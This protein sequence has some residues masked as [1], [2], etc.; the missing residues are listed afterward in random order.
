MKQK[1]F[2]AGKSYVSTSGQEISDSDK[3]HLHSVVDSG[4]YTDGRKC[5]EFRDILGKINAKKHV[6][7]TNSGSSA[8]LVAMS[9]MTER[10]HRPFKYILTCATGFPTTVAPIYQTGH[11]PIY[12][13]I[14]PENLQPDRNQTFDMKL[15]YAGDIGFVVMAHTLGFPFYEAYFADSLPLV[16]DGCDALG[17]KI[18]DKPVGYKADISTLSFFP[19]HH[20]TTGQGG[21]VLTDDAELQK[22]CDSYIHWGRH[23]FP[24]DT[25]ITTLSGISKIQ[26]IKNGDLVL[27]HTGNFNAVLGTS[28]RTGFSG[29]MT[30]IKSVGN[31]EIVSTSDHPFFVS[32]GTWKLA[33]DLV[34]GDV[35]LEAIPSWK[36]S[37]NHFYWEY[38]TD[39]TDKLVGHSLSFDID[40]FRLMGY[41][42][43]QGSIAK[44]LKGVSGYSVDKYFSYRVDFCFNENKVDVIDDLC[45]LM[46]RFFDLSPC[47]TIGK[48]SKAKTISFKSRSAYEFF[49]LFCGVG[50]FNKHI[51][52]DVVGYDFKKLIHLVHGFVL[53]DGNKNYQGYTFSSISYELMEQLR[54]ILLLNGIFVSRSCRTFDKHKQSIVNGRKIVQ[55]H[56]LWTYQLY[57]KNAERFSDLCGD[58][59]KSRSSKSL[60]RIVGGY[61]EHRILQ[62]WNEEVSNIPVYN[63]EVE[64]DN[65]YHAWGVAVHNCFCEPGQNNTCGKR[66]DNTDG[67]DLPLGWDHKYRFE[68]LGYNL[69]MTEFQAALGVSQAMILDEF[70]KKRQE[71]Y[72]KLLNGL[73]VFNEYISFVSVPEWSKPSPFGFPILVRDTAPFSAM[74]L[75]EYLEL[76]KVG[77]RRVFGG[78]LTRQPA[79]KN[80]YHIR[81]GDLSGSDKVMNDMLWIGCHPALTNEMLDYVI[82]TFDAFFKSKGL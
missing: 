42:I 59:Y 55:R 51:P 63:F 58:D 3:L 29:D 80:L 20:I 65:S 32:P 30:H 18:N 6:M 46:K 53:G 25:P 49:S 1:Q 70:T 8:S 38:R 77:T 60:S 40:L 10:V 62:V 21:A 19:A 35:L 82:S 50:A 69:Q 14:N 57:G 26:N 78:N 43:S 66:F 44:G 64:N 39:N 75:I 4:W 79:F 15:K 74:E 52:Y 54:M 12:V 68:R 45:V 11:V 41:W 5:T 17:S 67:T 81:A 13:D 47:V 24:F 61:S 33:K 56:D 16:S 73:F 7:L 22:I 27:S 23:C 71:H 36:S 37:K 28:L 72:A 9:A 76:N 2:I 31:S 48:N 34:I